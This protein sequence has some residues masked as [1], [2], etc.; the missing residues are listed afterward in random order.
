MGRTL[1]F[2]QLYV[3][4]VIMDIKRHTNNC[5]LTYVESD[6][7]EEQILTPMSWSAGDKMLTL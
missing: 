4:A 1:T 5:P 7:G 6:A 3:E 2:E